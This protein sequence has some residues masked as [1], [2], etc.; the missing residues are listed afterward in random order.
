MMAD[1]VDSVSLTCSLFGIMLLSIE[2]SSLSFSF[3]V[4]ELKL[5]SSSYLLHDR[6]RTRDKIFNESIIY[7]I[8]KA[9]YHV[10]FMQCQ[11]IRFK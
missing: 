1:T 8:N 3:K 6:C 5:V 10:I 9:K 2:L 7:K 4:V 11:N